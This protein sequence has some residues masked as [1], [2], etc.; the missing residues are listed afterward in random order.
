GQGLGRVRP[1]ELDDAPVVERDRQARAAA[2]AATGGCEQAA[3][4]TTA[5]AANLGGVGARASRERAA[6]AAQ[7]GAG[8]RAPAAAARA[9][10]PCVRDAVGGA[11]RHLREPAGSR[12]ARA[13]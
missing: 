2:T 11:G 5:P 10:Q 12:C 1:R 8:A 7:E 3:A 4:A 6:A 9:A 13:A